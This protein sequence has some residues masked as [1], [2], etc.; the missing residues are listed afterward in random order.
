MQ[1]AAPSRRWEQQQHGSR[2]SSHL[3]GAGQRDGAI[4]AQLVLP[5]HQ[6]L[7]AG[8]PLQE[9]RQAVGARLRHLV[10]RQVDVLRRIAVAVE[11]LF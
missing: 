8:A 11:L 1:G 6:A 4:V 10:Q 2:K 7:Q 9:R 3:Q 5:Q